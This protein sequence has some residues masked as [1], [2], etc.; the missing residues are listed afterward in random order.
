MPKGKRKT[1]VFFKILGGVFAITVFSNLIF[2]Y[3]L[4][5]GYEGV[6]SQIRPFL[7]PQSFRNVEVNI[8]NTWLVAASS[9]IFVALMVILFT[10]LFTGRMMKPL[11][12]LLDAVK[13]AGKGNL[14][15]KVELETK[16][17]IGE[18]ADEFN[19]MIKRLKEAREALEDEK[20][21]LEVRV[22]AR[23]KELEELAQSLDE[24][25]KER[26]KELQE[27]VEE[28]ERFHQLTVGRELKMVELKE[29][30]E[31][32]KKEIAEQKSKKG[33]RENK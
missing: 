4:Y 12:K 15:V 6:V 19:L 9:F 3:I 33:R 24:K 14:N 13:E 32:L 20:K 2:A 27:R 8:Y 5:N 30:L 25:V 21:V 22:R 18:L 28:L 1:S 31:R 23:T 17:E 7:S 16:D 26:T 11:K 29:E 10:V